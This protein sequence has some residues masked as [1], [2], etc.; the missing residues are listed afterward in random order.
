M[1]YLALS[2]LIHEVLY[3]MVC[4]YIFQERLPE[5]PL[6]LSNITITALFRFLVFQVGILP[7]VICLK[8][9]LALSC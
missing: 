8:H 3:I 9:L 4:V 5:V 1:L 6:F 2:F 7:I